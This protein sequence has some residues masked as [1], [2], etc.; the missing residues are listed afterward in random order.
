MLLDFEASPFVVMI[1]ANMSGKS[2]IIDALRFLST[3]NSRDGV[4][5][6]G[7]INKIKTR[8]D[9]KLRLAICA[10][11]PAFQLSFADSIIVVHESG[12][13]LPPY[14]GDPTGL[15]SSVNVSALG[16][17]MHRFRLGDS[18]GGAPL[19]IQDTG[20]AVFSHPRT[21]QAWLATPGERGED[22][23]DA[24]VR[25]PAS[26]IHPRGLNLTNALETI[27]QDATRW[28]ALM[29]DLQF[30]FPFVDQ[31]DF[32]TVMATR[33]AIRWRDKRFP[34]QVFYAD[35]MSDGML[36]YL[37]LLAMLHAADNASVLAFD[38]PEM[39][40]HPSLLGRVVSR[41]EEIAERGTPVIIATHSDR[42]LDHLTDPAAC[43]RICTA[44]DE[45]G[46][47]LTAL[48]SDRLAYWREEYSMSQ[49]RQQGQLD[50]GNARKP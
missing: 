26:R 9:L 18:L 29:D 34:G 20:I 49:L 27:Y 4:T 21:E 6:R 5:N 41:M 12:V 14:S 39:G 10:D 16:V 25:A 50:S 46:V 44:N 24:E 32:E 15:S 31:L 17:V 3:I 48:D 11:F 38:E 45:H 8:H 30:G 23:R 35:A 43:V 28:Q 33:V 1:G 13:A 7:G 47:K 40:L 2:T 42:L 36:G 37:M 22:P 19:S